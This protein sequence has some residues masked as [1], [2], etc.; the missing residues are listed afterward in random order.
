M[1]RCCNSTCNRLGVD[2]A[3]IFQREASLRSGAPNSAIVVCALTVA[4]CDVLF[5]AV[6]PL[7]PRVSSNMPSVQLT[8]VKECPD[9]GVLRRSPEREAS[10][11]AVSTSCSF[12][13]STIRAGTQL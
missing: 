4:L 11:I 5:M 2:V 9:P 13:A 12:D 1:G 3:L 7:S 6:I 8:E 10:T